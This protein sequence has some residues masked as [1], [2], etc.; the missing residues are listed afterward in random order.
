[1]VFTFSSFP[2][3]SVLRI[4]SQCVLQKILQFG[5]FW[6]FFLMVRLVLWMQGTN[7]P[8]IKCPCHIISGVVAVSLIAHQWC[9]WPMMTWSS[10]LASNLGQ[11][12]PL[13]T[14]FFSFATYAIQSIS[15]THPQGGEWQI[16]FLKDVSFF[17]QD[18]YATSWP[19]LLHTKVSGKY[20]IFNA[21]FNSSCWETQEVNNFVNIVNRH[22]CRI[23]NTYGDMLEFPLLFKCL[24]SWLVLSNWQLWS[25][26]FNHYRVEQHKFSIELMTF[27]RTVFP[28]HKQSGE[29][30]TVRPQF[31]IK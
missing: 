30:N 3:F 20:G 25:L 6:H 31:H 24:F 29:A 1:M 23:Q 10:R 26:W 15:V 18:F 28:W 27:Q 21:S 9:W 12:S 14:D 19:F 22:S 16:W 13:Y 8:E 17:L 7:A 4:P 5:F 2:W 11:V